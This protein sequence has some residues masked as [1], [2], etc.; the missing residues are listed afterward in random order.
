MRHTP[1]RIYDPVGVNANA[2]EIQSGCIEQ[3]TYDEFDNLALNLSV[4]Y[5]FR[6]PAGGIGYPGGQRGYY[7]LYG[8][9]AAGRPRQG[10]NA[11]QRTD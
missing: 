4:I 11:S 8:R 10:Q 6:M 1:V 7:V 2:R 3:V 5:I 9:Q